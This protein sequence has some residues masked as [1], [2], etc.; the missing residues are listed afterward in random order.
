MQKSLFSSRS[1]EILP[2][3]LIMVVDTDRDL[4]ELSEEIIVQ[5]S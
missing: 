1:L 2:I 4:S 3:Q 5:I